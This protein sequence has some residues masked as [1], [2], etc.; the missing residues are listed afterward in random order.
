MLLLKDLWTE[1]IALGSESSVGRGR[2]KGVSAVIDYADS[3]DTKKW[4]I[5]QDKS[6]A[7][8]IKIDADDV[9]FLEECVTNLKHYLKGG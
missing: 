8:K 6:D 3:R 4:Q 9:S 7:L 1:D 2:L 5:E